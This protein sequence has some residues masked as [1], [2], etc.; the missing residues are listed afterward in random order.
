MFFFQNEHDVIFAL[1]N[2]IFLF[3]L[4]YKSKDPTLSKFAEKW[5]TEK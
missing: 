4:Q 2:F 1:P 3:R 5:T